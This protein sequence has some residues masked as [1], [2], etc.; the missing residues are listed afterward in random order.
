[1]AKNVTTVSIAKRAGV[2]QSTVSRVL[3]NHLGINRA[4]REQVLA[5][6][7]ELGYRG[8]ARKSK[9]RIGIVICPL[10]EQKNM[11]ALDFFGTQ[12]EAQQAFLQEANAETV[13]VN[14]SAGADSLGLAPSKLQELSGAILLNS[15]SAELVRSLR[16][17]YIPFVVNTGAGLPRGISCDTVGPDEEE[18]CRRGCDFLLSRSASF[19]IMISERNIHRLEG[20][21]R[22][23]RLRDRPPI[24]ETDLYLVPTTD[25]S[26]FIDAT[27]RMIRSGRRPAAML[28]DFYDAAIAVRSILAFSG[29]R[30]P[31]DILLFTYSHSPAQDKLP[32]LFQDPA[33]LG[34]KAARRLLE[35]L[36]NPGDPPH[37]IRIPMTP[38]NLSIK[39]VV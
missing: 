35:L 25:I 7:R 15:P 26:C 39:G 14:L 16:E 22:E 33:L 23:L 10:P 1:M 31:E 32:A 34:R 2:S 37:S 8:G 36:E 17:Q 13:I 29:I 3:N 19:G 6:M 20:F 4:K 11:M 27:Y 12:I 38:V 30:M 28:I 9:R 21:Q 18:T 5:A 24:P